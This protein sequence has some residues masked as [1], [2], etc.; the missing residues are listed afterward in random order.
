M[1]KDNSKNTQ[2]AEVV[3]VS[4]ENRRKLVILRAYKVQEPTAVIA[5]IAV[6]EMMFG[7]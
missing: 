1:G 3:H 2:V 6:I 5:V 4:G 7:T